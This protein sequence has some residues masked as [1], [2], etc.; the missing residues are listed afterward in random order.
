MNIDKK[1]DFMLDRVHALVVNAYG[2]DIHRNAK[3]ANH[4]VMQ[5]KSPLLHNDTALQWIAI[6]AKNARKNGYDT[7]ADWILG[8]GITIKNLQERLADN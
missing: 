8:Q 1:I 4:P 5:N 2:M 7:E 6:A 3:Y